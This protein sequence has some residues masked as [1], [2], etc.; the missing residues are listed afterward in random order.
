MS[1]RKKRECK[2]GDE[3]KY[4]DCRDNGLNLVFLRGIHFLP[5]ALSRWFFDFFFALLFLP[6]VEID[7]YS[8][9]CR[10]RE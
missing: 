2:E 3:R 1:S 9:D 8:D 5:Q 6:G 4:R 7:Y 10:Y